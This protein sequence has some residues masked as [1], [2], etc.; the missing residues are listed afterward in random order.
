MKVPFDDVYEMSYNQR[1]IPEK[2][3]ID[4]ILGKNRNQGLF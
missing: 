2:E 1:Y 3:N 4:F